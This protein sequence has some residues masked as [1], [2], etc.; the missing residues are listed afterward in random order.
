MCCCASRTVCEL[1]GFTFSL[2]TVMV[3]DY[4]VAFPSQAQ[5]ERF[6]KRFFEFKQE[7]LHP[8]LRVALEVKEFQLEVYAY[9]D[10][11]SSFKTKLL[12]FAYYAEHGAS[13]DAV[14]KTRIID[15]EI[16]DECFDATM[17]EL[18][19]MA[20]QALVKMPEL[21]KPEVK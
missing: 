6:V 9:F 19:E 18:F 11:E 16:S 14:D 7:K 21:R 17:D 5:M 8:A 1:R 10:F 3:R 12:A 2:F 13:A 15:A 4:K 20:E